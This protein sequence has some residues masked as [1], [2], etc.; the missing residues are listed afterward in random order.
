MAH[1]LVHIASLAEHNNPKLDEI[2]R[3][4]LR[5]R[6]EWGKSLSYLE[7]KME[8]KVEEMEQLQ[9]YVRTHATLGRT[10]KRKRNATEEDASPANAKVPSIE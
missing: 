2:T 5:N 4:F 7:A 8:G 6:L 9:H 1:Y 3:H 10:G